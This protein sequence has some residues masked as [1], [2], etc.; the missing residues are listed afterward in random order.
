[1]AAQLWWGARAM[2]DEARFDDRMRQRLPRILIACI[3]MGAVLAGLAWML[4][5][6]LAS[7]GW[8][9]AA[10]AGLVAAGIVSYFGTGFAIGAFRAADLKSFRRQR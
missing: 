9:Y 7:R 5:P 1:M 10:L 4:E 2:G 6:A 3:V 8:R